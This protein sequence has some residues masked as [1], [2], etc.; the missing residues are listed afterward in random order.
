[1]AEVEKR[2]RLDARAEL[3]TKMKLYLRELLPNE[4]PTI[5]KDFNQKFDSFNEKFD[6]KLLDDV[7]SR[8]RIMKTEVSEDSLDSPRLPTEEEETYPQRKVTAGSLPRET[9]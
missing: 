6:Q 3:L 8:N 1:M 9:E 7:Q 2:A 5:L 4:L